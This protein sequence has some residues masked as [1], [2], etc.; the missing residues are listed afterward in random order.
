MNISWHTAGTC[1]QTH[2]YQQ[3]WLQNVT[4]PQCWQHKHV[5]AHAHPPSIKEWNQCP[6][7]ANTP[8]KH[9]T[10]ALTA[11]PKYSGQHQPSS[12]RHQRPRTCMQHLHVHLS[13]NPTVHRVTRLPAA[14][15]WNSPRDW[16]SC[17]RPPRSASSPVYRHTH[18]KMLFTTEPD[19]GRER[20]RRG[21][22]GEERRKQRHLPESQKWDS[23]TK[24]VLSGK[25]QA[26]G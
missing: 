15:N 25:C 22:G 17:R 2:V 7:E 24:G 5:A 6:C 9:L 4:C 3:A 16:G 1:I 21:W 11:S 10:P 20:I 19:G 18:A 26:G 12:R 23:D 14:F 8:W 13:L